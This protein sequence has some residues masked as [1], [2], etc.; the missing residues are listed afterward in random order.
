MDSSGYAARVDPSPFRHTRLFAA[1]ILTPSN[2][3]FLLF[4]LLTVRMQT[5]RRW[6]WRNAWPGAGMAVKL[7]IQQSEKDVG[8]AWREQALVVG[9]W[10]SHY[11]NGYLQ[12]GAC[13]CMAC[14]GTDLCLLSRPKYHQVW[15]TTTGFSLRPHVHLDTQFIQPLFREIQFVVCPAYSDLFGEIGHSR[16]RFTGHAWREKRKPWILMLSHEPKH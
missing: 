4:S 14:V 12:Q 9:R 16:F 6:R 13:A 10:G 1:G 15:M 2:P 5:S 11:A 3:M 8:W 7:E